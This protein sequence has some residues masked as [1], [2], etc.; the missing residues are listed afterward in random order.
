VRRARRFACL[1]LS[2]CLLAAA[3]TAQA[4]PGPPQSE[5][6]D[7]F[8][9]P[10]PIA[11]DD[12][13]PLVGIAAESASVEAGELTY[14]RVENRSDE[15]IEFGAEYRVQR[16]TGGKWRRAPGGP[17]GPFIQIA[18]LLQAGRSGSCVR[19]EV[20]DDAAPGRYRF[21]RDLI[22]GSGPARPYFAT[23]RVIP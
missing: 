20:P 7:E 16:F 5:T 19:Y 15:R 12:P 4:A 21:S 9:D 8:C 1:T 3:A 11:A 17:R 6:H 2:A 18:F 22:A 23:F 10:A 14:A 13:G